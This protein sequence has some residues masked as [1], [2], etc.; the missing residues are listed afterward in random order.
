[1][2][3]RESIV[4]GAPSFLT[5]A[6]I[7]YTIRLTMRLSE[8]FTKTRREAPK[9]EQAKN[10]ML[11]S[12][13]GFIYKEMAG[14]YT[15]LP[16][17]LR[18]IRRIEGIIRE[19]MERAGASEVLLTTLQSPALWE[20]TGRWS[21]RVVDNWFKTSLA[22]GSAL[23]LAHTHEEPL[24]ALLAHYV[25]SYRDLPRLVFQFQTKFRNELRAKSGILRGREFIMK[26]CYSFA[27]TEAE[28]AE[29]YQRMKQAY[30]RIFERV[31]IG[32]CTYFTRASGGSFSRASEEFQTLTDAGEDTIYIDPDTRTAINA[33]V[34]DEGLLRELKISRDWLVEKK[35][36]EV[37]NI[38]PLGTKFSEPL[39]LLFTDE[40]G[41]K[42]PVIMG[43]YGI[44]LGRLMG[45]VA[46]VLSDERGLVWPRS[47]APFEVHLIKIRNPKS[48]MRNKPQ[49][50][51][52]VAA[53][54]DRLYELLSQRGVSVLYD[55]R[56]DVSA[57]EQFA[58]ADLIGLPYRIVVSEKT[59][60]EGRVEM[61][62]RRSGTIESIGSDDVVGRFA[63]SGSTL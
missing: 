53:E 41:E 33:E 58:D 2:L 55:D 8:L 36:V 12:R 14:V 34:L 62:E 4:R 20:R 59:M 31:G 56:E 32:E 54:A 51:N 38:F 35:A 15:L 5:A 44:G 57:G 22:D 48:E 42:R 24:T 43:C 13:A 52:D 40:R 30:T 63:R 46:E 3:L 61:R 18:V 21:D 23:G 26:D 7:F 10:A 47:I 27:R 50:T 19:E 16:L 37:G 28:H 11:L 29:L 25:S 45:T 6:H 60:A 39:G 17:G 1:M 49:A 9:D